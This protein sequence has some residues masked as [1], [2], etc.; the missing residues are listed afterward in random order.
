MSSSSIS[1]WNVHY[2]FAKKNSRH[3]RNDGFVVVCFSGLKFGRSRQR[4]R[5]NDTFSPIT[6]SINVD[7]EVILTWMSGVGQHFH[8]E[9][10]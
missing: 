4:I 10:T 9:M 5:D 7:G 8:A 6:S 3:R 2:F 1:P